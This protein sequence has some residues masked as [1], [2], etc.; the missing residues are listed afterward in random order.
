MT[1]ASLHDAARRGHAGRRPA[2]AEQVEISTK[3]AGYIDRQHDEVARHARRRTLR[4]RATS[5]TATCAACRPKCSRSSNAHRPET[6]GQA[7]RIS[8]ITPA[9]ISL[10]LVH[11]KR[12]DRR[13]RARRRERRMHAAS[14]AMIDGVARTT[15]STAALE[16]ARRSPLDPAQRAQLARLPRAAR[17]MEPHLQPDRDPRARA[18]GH[19]PPAR[20]ARR[21]AAL[22]AARRRCACSTSARGGGLPGIPLAIARPD[23]HVALV[24]PIRRRRRS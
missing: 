13:R 16:R 14:A 10:L 22:A 9:A 19:A 23:W 7:A 20:L 11:L 4:C 17:E 5:T 6:I 8:G 24:D 3:Y 12:G 1:Y 18:H 21:A 2:V 15:R